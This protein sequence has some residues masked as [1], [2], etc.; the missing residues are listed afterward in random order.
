MIEKSNSIEVIFKIEYAGF[1]FDFERIFTRETGI[2]ASFENLGEGSGSTPDIDAAL[3]RICQE[4]LSNVKKHAAATYVEVNLIFEGDD[5]N[6]SIYDNGI[7]F[8]TE[9]RS[10][11]S[12]GITSMRERASLLGGNLGLRSEKAEAH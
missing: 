10:E 11:R 3:L 12:F 8:N 7:G 2:R 5:V 4:A 1:L 6:L 9:A